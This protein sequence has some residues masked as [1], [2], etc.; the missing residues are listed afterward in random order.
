MRLTV[1]QDTSLDDLTVRILYIRKDRMLQRLIRAVQSCESKIKATLDGGT[2]WV[3]VADIYYFESVDKRTFL[4]SAD[5][6]YHVEERLYQLKERLAVYGFVQVNKA[7]LLNISVLQ[8]I[9][10]LANSKMEGMLANGERVNISRRYIPEIKEALK[11][12]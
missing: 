5:C 12:Q 9:R 10:P 6:V 4:Y 3:S 1:E 11:N 7:C 2:V 8:K